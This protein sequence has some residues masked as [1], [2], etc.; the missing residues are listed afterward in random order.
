MK[1]QLL[2]GDNLAEL[3]KL[4]AWSVDLAYL[5]PPFNSGRNYNVTLEDS[6]AQEIAYRDTWTWDEVAAQ[7]YKEILESPHP[8]KKRVA[9]YLKTLYDLG[10]NSLLAYLSMMTPRLIELQRVLKKSTWSVYLH[11][12]P[13]AS[14]Y[15]KLLCDLIFGASF[16]R[17]EIIWKRTS[18]HNNTKKKC[19]SIHD[20]I[21]LYCGDKAVWNVQHTP[22]D[23]DYV[24]ESYRHVDLEDRRFKDSDL[25]ARSK[26]EK[27]IFEWKGKTPKTSWAHSEEQLNQFASEGRIYYT[28]SGM[29][30]LINH[31]DE[32]PGVPLQD[33]WMD[34]PPVTSKS[35][36][37]VNFEGQKPTALLERIIRTSSNP[38]DIVLDPFLGSGTTA[39]AAQ[40]LGRRWISIDLTN[41]SSQVARDRLDAEFGKDCYLEF[42]GSPV[43]L[44]AAKSLAKASR[45]G[46]QDWIVRELGGRNCGQGRDG[47]VDGFFTLGGFGDTEK[48]QE[49][50]IQVK[51]GGTD[52]TDLNSFCME[53]QKR[54]SVLGVF[55]AFGEKISSGMRE[56]ARQ[57][58]TFRSGIEGDTRE[59]NKVQILSVE[60][61]FEPN[62]PHGGLRVPGFVKRWKGDVIGTIKRIGRE[63]YSTMMDLADEM[64]FEADERRLKIG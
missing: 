31:L 37:S 9:S 61:F 59:F 2:Y 64:P 51:S 12:D 34:I 22:Y 48:L 45:Y 17:N 56:T 39:I 27:H 20:V 3:Q 23:E 57:Q 44:E 36:E 32:M 25:T 24:E 4:D 13:T 7:T 41:Q 21:L 11:C 55:V 5:D 14:H 30:R 19:G 26:N 49:G 6:R 54:G 35:K 46:F 63:G 18:A 1:N 40:R 33:I 58:G 47:G 8:L 52:L 15:L 29:P 38:G 43:D 10:P 50:L 60:N 28:R 62:L 16:F 42:H 53:L